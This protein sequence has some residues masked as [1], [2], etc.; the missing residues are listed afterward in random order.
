MSNSN[1]TKI[2]DVPEHVKEARGFSEV[3]ARYQ[4]Y[5]KEQKEMIENEI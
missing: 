3:W 1:E 4:K 5:L 2:E